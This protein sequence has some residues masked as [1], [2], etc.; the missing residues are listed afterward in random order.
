V[1]REGARTIVVVGAAGERDPGKRAPLGHA[2]VTGAE[3]AVFTEE[4]SRSE[5]TEE[6]LAQMA[7]GAAAAGA[8]EG[9][10]YLLEPDRSAAI[11]LALRHARPGDVVL[12][13]GKGHE[14]TLERATETLPWDE[15]AE[16]RA[17]LAE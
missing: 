12:L 16:A 7:Q 4:D 1:R 17:A 9:A 15:A 11:R 8:R 2:A 6:I 5:S 14:R 10:D 3:L 13:A